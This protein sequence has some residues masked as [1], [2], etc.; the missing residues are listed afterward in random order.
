M[1]AGRTLMGRILFEN[2][3]I[4]LHN[5][6]GGE[7]TA[8]GKISDIFTRWSLKV[9]AK[10]LPWKPTARFTGISIY[11]VADIN[12][13]TVIVGQQDFWDSINLRPD[14]SGEYQKVDKSIAT[15]DFLNQ[16]KP[17][18][19]QAQQSAAEVPYELLRR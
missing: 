17:G 1:L 4:I 9:T 16:L 13:R 12:G 10:V 15:N 11:K 8:D 14:S 19:F 2:A 5:V 18:G 7:I 3:K 6:T